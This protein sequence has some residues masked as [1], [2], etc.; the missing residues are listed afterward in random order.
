[1]V[2][3]AAAGSVAAGIETRRDRVRSALGSGVFR[4]SAS[5]GGVPMAVTTLAEEEDAHRWPHFL[6]EGGHFFYT[7]VTGACCPPPKPARD[8]GWIARSGRACRGIGRG[9]H[10]PATPP[11]H[12]LFARDQTLMVQAFDPAGRKLAPAMP[13]QS[14]RVSAEDLSRY[15]SASRLGRTGRSWTPGGTPN[16]YADWLDRPGKILGNLG[17]GAVDVGLSLS[18]DQRQVASR[19]PAGFRRTSTSLD[20]RHRPQ[21]AD[22]SAVTTDGSPKVARLVPEARTSCSAAAREADQRRK[23]GQRGRGP[24]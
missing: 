24:V 19:W 11:D 7:A 12:L 13:L 3:D 4:V 9:H 14:R 20:D 18:P 17:R 6:P 10:R 5:A 2:A 15:V 8:Q 16:P 22:R 23:G 1:M 21:A